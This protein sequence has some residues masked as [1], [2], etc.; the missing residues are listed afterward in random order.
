MAERTRHPAEERAK[1]ELDAAIRVL[2]ES[3]MW[4]NRREA[5]PEIKEPLNRLHDD[6]FKAYMDLLETP[7]HALDGVRQQ[8]YPG[9]RPLA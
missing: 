1:Q 2:D 9:P 8:V 7:P 3:I 5:P 6:I 4:A